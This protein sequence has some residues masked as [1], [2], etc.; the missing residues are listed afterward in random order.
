MHRHAARPTSATVSALCALVA[1]LALPASAGW[2]GG[3]TEGNG[4]LT[5][6]SYD[7]ADCDAVLLRCGLDVRV[8]FGPVQSV[9]LTV[10]EN[11]VELYAIEARDGTLVIDAEDDP[12]PEGDARLE[13]TL[14]ALER[15]KLT[16]AGD[17]EIDGFD[18]DDLELVI[19]GAGDLEIDGRAD[20]LAITLN[21]AGD[22]DARRLEAREAEVTVNG[23]GD[24]E[25]HASESADVTING[26]GDIDVYGEPE[27]FARAVHGIGDIER[28]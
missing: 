15:F 25:V 4:E 5:T 6:R 2:F 20:R 13:I 12:R 1:L 7:L 26:V 10:D 17:I 16:G 23:A 11:L 27:H 28:H 8:S 19:E 9:A 24:V 3:G 22:V 21:G 18:G 14:T